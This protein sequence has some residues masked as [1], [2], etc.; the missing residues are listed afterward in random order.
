MQLNKALQLTVQNAVTDLT[1]MLRFFPNLLSIMD[2]SIL[3]ANKS[4]TEEF[5]DKPANSK[6]NVAEMIKVARSSFEAQKKVNYAMIVRSN[7]DELEKNP[8]HHMAWRNLS[9]HASGA[10]VDGKKYSAKQCLEMY[11]KHKPSKP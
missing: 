9:T 6:K 1:E 7:E 3:R 8:E 10:T 2:A 4:L 5:K 11:E